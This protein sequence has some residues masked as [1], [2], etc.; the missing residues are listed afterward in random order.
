[1]WLLWQLQVCSDN[2]YE[3]WSPPNNDSCLLGS[4][5]TLQRRKQFADCFNDK[6]WTRD[7]AIVTSCPC[8]NVGVTSYQLVCIVLLLLCTDV[9]SKQPHAMQLSQTYLQQHVT[10]AA[11]CFTCCVLL[12]AKLPVGLAC[13]KYSCTVPIK[14][15]CRKQH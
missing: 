9:Q 8:E 7:E 3:V 15:A 13:F 5:V 4:K 14:M 6:R 11:S 10:F 12:A 2:D 1:M